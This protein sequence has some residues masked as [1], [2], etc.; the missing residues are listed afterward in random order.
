MVGT[1]GEK[2]GDSFVSFVHEIIY[3]K[4][5]AVVVE[6][7][8][9]R[10]TASEIYARV[11]VKQLLVFPVAVDYPTRRRIYHDACI[12]YQPK[13]KPGLAATRGTRNQCRERMTER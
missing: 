1:F 6:I 11:S 7:L 9:V 2:F 3:Y 12:L 4:K 8:H 10:Q 13:H 5:R